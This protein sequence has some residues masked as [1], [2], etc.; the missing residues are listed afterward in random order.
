VRSLLVVAALVGGSSPALADPAAAQRLVGE[1]ELAARA[2]DFATAAAKYRAAAAED[3]RTEY[4]CNAGVAYWKQK[5]LPRAHLFLA[6]CI[7]GAGSLDAEFARQVRTVLGTVEDRLRAGEYAP[8]EIAV[9]PAGA[10]IELDGDAVIDPR[11]LWLA[12]GAHTVTV[13]A[14]GRVDH[15]ETLTITAR[16]RRELRVDLAAPA[17]V[18]A[19]PVKLPPPAP[20]RVRRS[21]LPALATTL[22]AGALGAGAALAFLSARDHASTANAHAQDLERA[23]YDDESQRARRLQHISWGLAGAAVVAAG[24]SA[25]MWY[26]SSVSIEVAPSAVAVTLAGRF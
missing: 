13:R 15:T 19:T 8:L 21:K 18:A 4:V 16:D 3:P 2:N 7:V 5:D 1:A 10:T 26:R 20:P 17:P 14:A 6:R 25:Y 23:T 11:L 9:S 24:A 12:F 22:A